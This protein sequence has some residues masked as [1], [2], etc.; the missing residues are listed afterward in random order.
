MA[1]H[2]ELPIY[3]RSYDLLDLVADIT[4]NMPR[5]FKS[6]L[7]ARIREE[8]VQILVLI[9]RANAAANKVPHQTELLER[10]HVA[11]LLMRLSHDKRFISRKQYAR[12]AEITDSIGRQAGGWRKQSAALPAA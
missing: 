11:Q 3:K 5:D 2:T 7:G 9:G 6:S 1:I 4:R 8:C 10:L 12:A